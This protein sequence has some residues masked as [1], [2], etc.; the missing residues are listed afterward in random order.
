AVIADSIKEIVELIK[1]H[2]PTT[3]IILL[4]LFP[5]N[6]NQEG[7]SFTEQIS[8]VNDQLARWKP[9]EYLHYLDLGPLL[10][11]DGQ[12]LDRTLSDDGLHL[13]AEGYR[14][15]GPSLQQFIAEVFTQ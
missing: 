8:E 10:S 4:G 5:R 11:S 13:N 6:P 14:R 12:Y 2:Q 15:I 3:K 7:R 1:E 9:G